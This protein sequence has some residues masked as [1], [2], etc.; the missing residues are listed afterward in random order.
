MA[1]WSVPVASRTKYAELFRANDTTRSGFLTGAQARTILI[2]SGLPQGVLAQIW[3]LSD[4]DV[5]GRLSTEEFILAMHLVDLARSSLPLPA[6]LTP[7]LVPPSFRVPRRPSAPGITPTAPAPVAA[8]PDWSV[9]IISRQKYTELFNANDT[10]RSGVLTG[11]QA[12]NILLS[13]GVPPPL[14]AQVWNLADV[15]ANGNL[16]AEEFILAMHLIDRVR[17]GQQLPPS[18]TPDLMPPSFRPKPVAAVAPAAAIGVV[19][20]VQTSVVPSQQ[21]P[22]VPAVPVAPQPSALPPQVPPGR[23]APPPGPIVTQQPPIP[24]APAPVVP[25]SRSGS[26]T[27]PVTVQSPTAAWA[28]PQTSR[29]TYTQQ[30]FAIDTFKTGY[31]NGSQAKN[32][33]LTSGLPQAVLAQIWNLSDIDVDGR[34]SLE[35]FI[36]ASYLIELA[37]SGKPLPPSLPPDLVPPS[38]RKP[39]APTS[40]TSSISEAGPID[41]ASLPP[42]V[43]STEWAIPQQSK[44]KYV[45]TFNTHDRSR[46]GFLTGVQARGILV[47]SGLTQDILAKIWSLCDVTASGRLNSEEF[48]LAMHL[49]DLAKAGEPV[50]VVL[51][52]ELVPPCH[53]RRRGS[54][55]SSAAS[56]ANVVATVQVTADPNDSPGKIAT[57]ED[58][59]KENFE[60][61]QAVLDRKRQVLLDQ[62]KREQEERERKEREEQAKREKIRLEMERKRQEEIERQLQKQREIEEEREEARKAELEK[63]EAARRELERQRLVEWETQRINEL[64]NQKQKVIEY[65]AQLKS[66]KTKLALDTESVNNQFTSAQEA[67]TEARNK[68]TAGK[69]VIDSM[70]TERDAKLRELNLAN[71]TKKTLNEKQ[72]FIERERERIMRELKA[73]VKMQADQAASGSDAAKLALQNKQAMIAQLKVQLKEAEDDHEQKKKDSEKTGEQLAEVRKELDELKAKLRDLHQLYNAKLKQGKDVKEEYIQKQMNFDPNA[74]WGEPAPAPVIVGAPVKEESKSTVDAN[75][76]KIEYNVLF[77]FDA[78]NDDELTL[79]AGDVVWVIPNSNADEGWLQGEFKGSVGWFPANYAEPASASSSALTNTAAATTTTTAATVQTKTDSFSSTAIDTSSKTQVQPVTSGESVTAIYAWDAKESNQISFKKGDVIK[80]TEKQDEWWFG[81]L[82]NGQSGWF[83]MSF[84]QDASANVASIEEYYVTLY[85][86]ESQE[87]GDLGFEVN[88]VVKVVKKDGEWWTGEIS[89]DRVGVFPSNYVRPAEADEIVSNDIDNFFFRYLFVPSIPLA[90]VKK[91][92]LTLC[93]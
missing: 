15:D 45:Q 21:I 16:T 78:T 27:S 82:S 65:I 63:R 89:D 48:V 14:L 10:L 49:I 42:A 19:S 93:L 76:E 41:P 79:R 57:F 83:P 53:R 60:R 20:P 73:E 61:G 8:I 75:Q 81:E 30:F 62:Q 58:K 67:L 34:L 4:V 91:N 55:T 51:P 43:I 25:G 74:D 92:C 29:Y 24:V 59:R 84:V 28:I 66:R 44:L 77:D 23:P 35:E 50:P 46:S 17:A 7:D 69:S 38:Y 3:N 13:T 72:Q 39:S 33:L 86:F 9:P 32:V 12:K 5:D 85:A 64:Q 70:R 90:F 52:P 22:T 11:G 54:S 71:A 88:E 47:Q 37:K 80:V 87:P 31:L 68:V 36:L 18:L 56:T 26:V 2:N 40:R 6:T 1:D